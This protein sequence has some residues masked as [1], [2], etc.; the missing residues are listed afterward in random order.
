[1]GSVTNGLPGLQPHAAQNFTATP[2]QA[3]PQRVDG[4]MAVSVKVL[5][6]T[7][8]READNQ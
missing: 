4:A 6:L 7:E 2:N 1:V 8:Y 3:S 5:G